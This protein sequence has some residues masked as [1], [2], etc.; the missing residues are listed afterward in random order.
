MRPVK[1]RERRQKQEGCVRAQGTG[2]KNSDFM[3]DNRGQIMSWIKSDKGNM[4]RIL[5]QIL[6]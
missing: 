5:M 1:F 4:L 3:T 6:L 2:P